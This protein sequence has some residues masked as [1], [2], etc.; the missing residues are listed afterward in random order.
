[1]EDFD[2]DSDQNEESC[3]D[4]QDSSDDNDL[5]IQD[6]SYTEE[7]L[8]KKKC[9]ELKVLC[10]KYNLYRSRNKSTLIKR[11]LNPNEPSNKRQ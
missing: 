5:V 9:G 3:P 8:K 10:K 11:L 7:E 4:D 1:M 2:T 6:I